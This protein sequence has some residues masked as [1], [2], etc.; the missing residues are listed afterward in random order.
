MVVQGG[1]WNSSAAAPPAPMGG[2]GGPSIG[3]QRVSKSSGEYEGR[4]VDGITAPIGVRPIPTKDELTKFLTQCESLDKWLVAELLNKKLTDEFPFA[5]QMK[6]LTTLEALIQ[7]GN[8]DVE[9]YLVENIASIETFEESSNAQIRKVAIHILELCGLRDKPVVAPTPAPTSNVQYVPAHAPPTDLF[10]GLNINSSTPAPAAA[11]KSAQAAPQNGFGFVTETATHATPAPVAAQASSGFDF[12]GT[13]NAAAPSHSPAVAPVQSGFDF[14]G[15]NTAT[16][17][18]PAVSPAQAPQPSS[19]DLFDSAPAP[20]PAAAPAPAKTSADP[21]GDFLNSA[22]STAKKIDPVTLLLTQAKIKHPPS[23]PLFTPQP[24][25]YPQGGYPPQGYPQQQQGGYP[26]YGQQGGYPPYGQP[27]G[28][29]PPYGQPQGGYGGFPPQQGGY[30][31]QQQGGFM[32]NPMGQ[33]FGSSGPIPAAS[34]DPFAFN[35]SKPTTA[36]SRPNVAAASSQQSGFGFMGE[37]ST[38]GVP[39]KSDK[40]DFVSDMLKF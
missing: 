1:S 3:T 10:G 8:E 16:H 24:N 21:L 31:P 33:S 23:N 36:S 40:F 30:P 18:A 4:L 34:S 17:S 35:V 25:A 15:S 32:G 22:E 37:E 19:F 39:T 29:Y 6:A 13:S 14:M 27:Q 20:A 11:A 12:M 9:D 38:T 28:G 26:P 5:T 2:F 7:Q